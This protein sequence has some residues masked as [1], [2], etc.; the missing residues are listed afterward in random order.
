MKSYDDMYAAEVDR[1]RAAR[2]K[3]NE[4]LK[5]EVDRLQAIEAR[6]TLLLSN[7]G[8]YELITADTIRKVMKQ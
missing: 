7:F 3:E 2:T 6:L 5:R 1:I 4:D 8:T